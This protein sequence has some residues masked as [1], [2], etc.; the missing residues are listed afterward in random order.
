MILLMLGP[1]SDHINI[2]IDISNYAGSDPELLRWFAQAE[3]MH[4]RWAMLA[5]SGIL[6]PEWLHKVG[7]IENFSW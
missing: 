3:L 2:V 4:S 5:V 7:F 6:I 1:S